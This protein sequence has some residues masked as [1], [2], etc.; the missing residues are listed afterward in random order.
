MNR[1]MRAI[2]VL[3]GREEHPAAGPPAGEPPPDRTTPLAM[4]LVACLDLLDPDE[5]AAEQAVTA[6]TE[7]G[8]V[9]I[10]SD[11]ARFDRQW[12]NAQGRIDTDDPS[13]DWIVANTVRTGWVR[14]E[15]ILRPAQVWVY[16]L[17]AADG[18]GRP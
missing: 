2:A 8:V 1:V 15:R 3:R 4:A 18:S 7:A 13:R 10:D 5:E 11:G 9:A 12:H 14:G 17:T 16:R 6:L